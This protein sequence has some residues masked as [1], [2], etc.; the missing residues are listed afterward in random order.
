MAQRNKVIDWSVPVSL[1]SVDSLIPNPGL[2]GVFTGV[3]NDVMIIGGGANFPDAMPWDGGKKVYHSDIY[4]LRKKG[5]KIFFWN[6]SQKFQLKE[7]I[8]YG[9]SVS[10]DSGIVCI[11]GESQGGISNRVF[12]LSWDIAAKGIMQKELPALPLPLCNSSAVIEKNIVYVAGGETTGV[13]SDKF[14]SL[15]LANTLAGWQELPKLPHPVSHAVVAVQSNGAGKSIYLIGGRKKNVDGISELFNT[16][17]EFSLD[18]R[19]WIAKKSLDYPLCAGT[20]LPTANGEIL[21]FGGDKGETFHKVEELIAAIIREDDVVK[22]QHLIQKKNKLQVSHPGFSNEVLCYCP[23][24]D[25]WTMVG[26]IPFS[27]PVTTTAVNWNGYCFIPS[28]EIKA[29][30]RTSQIL[31]GKLPKK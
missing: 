30:V 7:A 5:K 16:V 23:K 24:T 13:V 3:T 26:K 6:D 8:A 9:A 10:N 4:V 28:G 31:M 11:G 20:G 27:V 18:N 25:Q 17:Y 2:A 1:P 22:K 15:D 21:V 12:S 29:G 14:L 19:M